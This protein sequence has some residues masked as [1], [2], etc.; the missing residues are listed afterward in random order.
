[1]RRIKLL[2]FLMAI[3]FVSKNGVA[4]IDSLKK[5]LQKAKHDTLKCS[6]LVKMIEAENDPSVWP[7]FNEQLKSIAEKKLKIYPEGSELHKTYRK[8][9]AA[10][11]NNYGYLLTEKGDIPQALRYFEKSM[12]QYEAIGNKASVAEL[13]NN[14]GVIYYQINN[15][16]KA[17]EYYHKSLTT[18]EQLGNKSRIAT[19]CNNIGSIYDLTGDISKALEYFS[20]SVK[21][22][23]ETGDK[24]GLGPVFNNI[25]LIYQRQEQ[26]EKALEYNFKSLKAYESVSD[27]NGIALAYNNIGLIYNRLHQTDKAIEYYNRSFEI[28]QKTGNKGGM[29]LILNNLGYIYDQKFDEANA[30]EYYTK[31]LNIY[32]EINNPRGVAYSLNNIGSV[33][34][35][36]KRFKEALPYALKSLQLSKSIGFPEN[37]KNSAGLCSKVYEGLHNYKAALENHELFVVMG[38]SILNVQ[39]KKASLKNQ[40]KYEYEKKAAADSVKN[41]EVQKVKDAQLIAQQAQIKQEKFQRYGLLA[42]LAIVFLGLGFAINRFR[43][44]QK[45]KKIIEEQKIKVDHAFEA[46]AEKNKEVLDSIHYAKRIQTALVTNEKYIHKSLQRLRKL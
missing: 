18:Q 37:I 6:L 27:K 28:H 46:L 8:F 32:Q 10:Y 40:I 25:A 21:L 20:R 1:M 38:D 19:C 26:N 36:Q 11:L 41:A 31:S 9:F 35:S 13:Q 7:L 33:Y 15:I 45:Q 30:L 39:T 24:M 34:L 16:S 22:Y 3:L 17:L 5:E 42:G 4:Q 2:Y 29:A 14:I 23:E 43:V 44:T 12:E